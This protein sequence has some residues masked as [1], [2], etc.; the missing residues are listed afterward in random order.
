MSISAGTSGMS[1]AN[2]KTTAEIIQSIVATLGICI[3]GLWTYKLFVEDRLAYPH[4]KLE[5]SVAPIALT[6]EVEFLQVILKVQNSGQTL[7][8]ISR[9][10]LRIQQILPIDGCE[11]EQV[12]VAQELNNAANDID[13]T[14]DRFDWPLITEREASWKTPRTVEPGEDD[15]LDFEFVIPASSQVVRI[16]GYVPNDET[17]RATSDPQ[18]WSISR[19]VD[20]RKPTAMEEKK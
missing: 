5:V 8:H 9:A 19:V 14:A 15:S 16:Y 7:M 6:D 18:G 4:A 17:S 11:K 20:L 3:G 1:L 2:T 10:T 13:R 12:C